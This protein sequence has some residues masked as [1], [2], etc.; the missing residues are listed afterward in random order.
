MQGRD[1]VTVFR[2]RLAVAA[3][4]TAMLLATF[5]A[6][7]VPSTRLAE[8]NVAVAASSETA[9]ALVALVAA[10]LVWG[11][12]GRTGLR[13][14]L[15]LAG[16]LTVLAGLNLFFAA[17]PVATGGR[18]QAFA[19][20]S[21][22]L[23]SAIAAVVL[24][25]A[26]QSGEAVVRDVPRA[27][28]AAALGAAATLVVVAIIVGALS[29]VLPVGVDPSQ[30]P[31]DASLL[32]GDATLIAIQLFTAAGYAIAAVGFSSAGARSHDEFLGWVGI[33]AALA[34]GAKINYALFPTAYA[35]WLSVPDALRAAAY[36]V[37]LVGA[38]REIAGYQRSLAAAARLEER[39]RLAREL[40]DG[41]TQDIALI[42]S[43][44]EGRDGPP[45]ERRWEMMRKAAG[46][47]WVESR[48]LMGTLADPDPE[49]LGTA[50]EQTVR[51]AI[52]S[53]PI[54]AQF[55]IPPGVDA[56]PAT[57]DA[58]LRVAREAALNAARHADARVVRVEL[59]NGDGVRLTIR[60]DGTGF[61]PATT[62]GVGFG[63]K[64][65]RQRAEML[66]S[67]LELMSREGEGTRVSIHVPAEAEVRS[68]R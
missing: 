11:R 57:R 24:A 42:A 17:V 59:D 2:P 55:D 37:L 53:F 4:A 67:R 56:E 29:S 58:L 7:L 45:G 22:T 26:A 5:V 51:D 15:L 38:V 66:G 49:P 39:Q 68:R 62:N 12:F 28:R 64:S 50:L 23:A 27:G 44:G 14:D 60:D 61:A 65:M 46:R 20:W 33:A 19:I 8:R 10:S 21:I 35:S 6:V 63:L 31:A 18:D 47:A 48:A 9:V 34:C 1:S 52:G 40:H 36:V 30:S 25:V 41:L 43:L 54:E 13:R 3:V 32:G 16:G